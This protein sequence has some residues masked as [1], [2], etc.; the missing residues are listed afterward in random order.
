MK[1][2]DYLNEGIEDRGIFKA[3]FMSGIPGAGKSFTIS[4]IKSGR[5]EPRIVNVDKFTEFL[6]INDIFSVYDKSKKLTE[7]QLVQ[8]INSMLPLF[9]DTTGYTIGRLKNRKEALEY[10]GY[11]VGMVFVNTS[12]ETSLERAEKRTRRVAPEVIKEYYDK[13]LK[14]QDSISNMFDYHQTINNNDGELTDDVV[15][16]AYNK[17]STFYYDKV[18]NSVGSTIFEKMKQN[19]LKY[20]SPD[21]FPLDEIKERISIWFRK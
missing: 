12:L 19:N 7:N 17:V 21:I 8:Y 15:I 10:F 4:K 14:F 20:L 11:D 2:N 5:I 9:I 18:K 16:K 1:F 3:I 6:N 13:A